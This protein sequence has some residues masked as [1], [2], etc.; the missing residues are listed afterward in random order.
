MMRIKFKGQQEKLRIVVMSILL[1]I[2]CYLVYYFHA[3]AETGT[4]F[5]HFFYVPVILA[6]LWWRRKG[7]VVAI[8][9]AALLVVSHI[10][11]RQGMMATA[12]DFVRAAMF[13]VVAIVFALLSE[14]MAKTQE[15]MQQQR[16]K[17]WSNSFDSLEDVMLIID[18]DYNIEN[19]NDKGSKLFGKSKEE[20]IGKKCYK[21]I[22]NADGPE[23][24][25]PFEKTLKIKN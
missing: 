6:S 24:F 8:F 9:L 11:L 14:R 23:G 1:A 3:V 16:E 19:I 10:F 25:C 20:I 4:V 21:I 5:T 2:C 15:I 13:I 7:V 18:K 12:D 22:H 17:D